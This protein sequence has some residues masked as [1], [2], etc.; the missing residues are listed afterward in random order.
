MFDT[1]AVRNLLNERG[2]VAFAAL[3]QRASSNN[4]AAV[5]DGGVDGIPDCDTILWRLRRQIVVVQVLPAA[6]RLGNH[7]DDAE[8]RGGVDS[9]VHTF[10]NVSVH[11]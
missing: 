3:Q 6:R 2:D 8:K 4:A 10:E 7:G 1:R 9:S 5:D 11:T